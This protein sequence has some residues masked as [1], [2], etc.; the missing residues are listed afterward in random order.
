M[1]EKG[2]RKEKVACMSKSHG[3]IL[4]LINTCMTCVIEFNTITTCMIV[5]KI[6]AHI[7]WIYYN[8]HG[9]IDVF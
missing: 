4:E 3:E 7:S 5:Y 2:K 6:N 1:A 8:W 9:I